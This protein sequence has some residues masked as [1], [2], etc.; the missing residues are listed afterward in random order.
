MSR[1]PQSLHLTDTQMGS[2]SG[3][4]RALVRY[5]LTGLPPPRKVRAKQRRAAAETSSGPS[6]SWTP[7]TFC[8]ESHRDMTRDPL[9]LYSVVKTARAAQ[10]IF[11]RGC[12][13]ET[14]SRGVFPPFDPRRSFGIG[15]SVCTRCVSVRVRLVRFPFVVRHDRKYCNTYT[16]SQYL[17][18]V[19]YLYKDHAC[20]LC[21][22]CNA[23]HECHSWQC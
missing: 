15:Y 17:L 3:S 10:V 11:E 19:Q 22:S 23:C 14:Q 8:D 9:D 18:S 20:K 1:R 4:G 7:P 13:R 6:G 5:A 12:Y 21:K 2:S 16:K